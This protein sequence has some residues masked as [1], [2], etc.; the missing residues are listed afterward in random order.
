MPDLT[1]HMHPHD[2]C[3]GG[4]DDMGNVNARLDDGDSRMGR[5][6]SVQASMS[7]EQTAMR[8]EVGEVLEILRMGKS[9]FKAVGYFGTAVKWLAGIIA[10]L[11][12]VYLAFKN[13]GKS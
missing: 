8:A 11:L 3:P 1:P 7:A 13:G 10:P 5:I 6:E 9:F 4:C 2:P 12:A